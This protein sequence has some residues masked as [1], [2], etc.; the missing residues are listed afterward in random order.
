MRIGRKGIAKDLPY[1]QWIDW[2]TY[3]RRNMDDNPKDLIQVGYLTQDMVDRIRSHGI[4]VWYA[5]D[6]PIPSAVRSSDGYR[7]NYFATYAE[8][9][10]ME[11]MELHKK[12]KADGKFID[13]E[14]IE[15]VLAMGPGKK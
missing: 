5:K 6:R 4:R 9:W 11:A 8:P 3:A 2:H 14:T 13:M 12:I 15:F 10:F 7:Y 1:E